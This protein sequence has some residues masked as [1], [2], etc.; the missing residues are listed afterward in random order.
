[1]NT[2]VLAAMV[3]LASSA[4]FGQEAPLAGPAIATQ[5]PHDDVRI[6]GAALD[7]AALDGAIAVEQATP[8]APDIGEITA[9]A[10]ETAAMLA[11]VAQCIAALPALA[12]WKDREET[13]PDE[14]FAALDGVAPGAAQVT[15]EAW[16]T[17]RADFAALGLPEDMADAD[18][19]AYLETLHAVACLHYARTGLV[20]YDAAVSFQRNVIAE[21]RGGS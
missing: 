16:V 17:S 1:M 4:A 20:N 21:A 19:T 9:T 3:A 7:S 12:P 18:R 5:A 14:V 15:R 6:D 13:P 2:F 11:S 8:R 10:K